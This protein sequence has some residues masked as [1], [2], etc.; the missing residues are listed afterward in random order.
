M[1]TKV[2]KDALRIY[3][4]RGDFLHSGCLWLKS[5]LHTMHQPTTAE[6]T[7][8]SRKFASYPLTSLATSLQGTKRTFPMK[9]TDHHFNW[10]VQGS[11]PGWFFP[12]VLT[13]GRVKLKTDFFSCPWN[14]MSTLSSSG[15]S[16]EISSRGTLNGSM[17]TQSA[18]WMNM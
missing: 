17:T 12:L 1:I 10:A 9:K 14:L 4:R 7:R 13:L 6:I 16:S 15:M 2:S 8:S 3:K 5:S 18:K 11:F